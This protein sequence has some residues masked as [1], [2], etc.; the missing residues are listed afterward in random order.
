MT[1]LPIWP[2]NLAHTGFIAA[3]Q[4]SRSWGDLVTLLLLGGFGIYMRRFGWPRPALLIGFV[5]APGAENYLYQA[6]Q[7][8]DWA[9]LLRPGVIIIALITVVSVFLGLRFGAEISSEGESDTADQQ[10]R[11]RQLAF[12]AVLF[13]VAAYCVFEAAQLSFLAMIFPLTIG[14]LALIASLAVI[15]RIRSGRVAEIHDDDAS[16]TVA[17]KSSGREKYLAVFAGLVALIWL[18]GFFPAMVIFFPAFL[19]VA[20]KARPL[21]AAAMTA[22]AVG[23]IGL[24]TWAMTLRLPEGLLGQMLF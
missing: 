9:W 4:A 2:S 24:I 19:I 16:L 12:A 11:G 17:G 3:F 13:L 14:I 7:F 6:V 1:S 5:L 8:Y 15:L 18:I 21:T 23:F 20:G 10:T 22:G